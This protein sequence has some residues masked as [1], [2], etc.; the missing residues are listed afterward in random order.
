MRWFQPRPWAEYR[1]FLQASLATPAVR[2]ALYWL[3]VRTVRR[4]LWR[5]FS[6][7]LPLPA[8]DSLPLARVVRCAARGGRMS[9]L[10]P[11]CLVTALVTEAL[12]GR[13]GHPVDFRVGVLRSPGKF[14][15][16]AW[17]EHEGSV[18]VGGPVSVIQQYTAL[19]EIDRLWT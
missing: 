15:A 16:H 13:H 4:Y 8:K 14:A 3:P 19:P 7:D 5:I 6:A 10:A 18:V 9:P 17:L 1:V 11:T 12:L 2:A